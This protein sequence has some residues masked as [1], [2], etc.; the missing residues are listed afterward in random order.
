MS[1]TSL[2]P[3]RG[4]MDKYQKIEKLGEGTYGVVY[5]AQHKQTKQIVAL[6]RIRLDDEDEVP[7]IPLVSFPISSFRVFLV[8]PFAKFPS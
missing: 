3:R 1:K 2:L 7:R 4:S 6:K 8:R 5:K